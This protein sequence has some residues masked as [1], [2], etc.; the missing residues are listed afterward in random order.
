MGEGN[1]YTEKDIPEAAPPPT[2]MTVRRGYDRAQFVERMHDD[3]PKTIFGKTGNYKPDDVVDLI[4]DRPEPLSYLAKR[5]WQFFG[6]AEPS[7]ADIALVSDAL[8]NNNWDIA[9]ALKAM[10]TSPSFYSADEK[11]VLIKSPVEL[12]AMTLR[13]LEEPTAPRLMTASAFGMRQLG[14]ELFQL[15]Q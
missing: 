5:L 12:E 7:A 6:T 9:P 10:F 14:Q 3:Q 13:L 8:R 1:G 2:G 11:F 4:F 15:L